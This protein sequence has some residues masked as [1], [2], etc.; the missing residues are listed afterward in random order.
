MEKNTDQE[1][2]DTLREILDLQREQLEISRQQYERAERLNDR[3]EAIQEKSAWLV[4]IGR[5]AFMV[6]IPV[7][8]ILIIYV[9]W[10]L[11]TIR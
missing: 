10:L 5:K 1:I 11:L 6:I 7:L 4:S 8:I 3:A 2:L 9:S